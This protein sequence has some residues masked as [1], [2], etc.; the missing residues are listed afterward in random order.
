M[1]STG[2]R[3]L[4]P[5]PAEG[6]EAGLK[7]FCRQY[8]L[9]GEV[10][11]NSAQ[12]AGNICYTKYS[13]CQTTCNNGAYQIG[14]QYAAI[15]DELRSLGSECS[16]L[17]EYMVTLGEQG[18]DS[19][20]AAVYSA[21]CQQ[22]TQ[23]QAQSQSQS[24]GQGLGT[25]AAGGG[26][27]PY[28]DSTAATTNDPC[29]Q[30][31]NSAACVI[32]SNNPSH[33]AC[34]AL[35]TTE[36]KGQAGFKDTREEQEDKLADFNVGDPSEALNMDSMFA[37]NQLE[38][39]GMKYQTVAN[40]S[41][42]GIPGEGG[43]S[44]P[45][46]LGGGSRGSPGSPGYDT[47]VDEGFRSGGGGGGALAGAGTGAGM[48]G[49]LGSEGYF[50]GYGGS[51]EGDRSPSS[52][53]PGMDLSQYLPGGSRDPGQHLGGHRMRP[54]SAEIN[55]KFVDIWSRITVRMQEKCRLGEL[56]GCQ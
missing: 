14:G 34:V 28:S 23:A 55:G 9:T 38:P 27:E 37:N 25:G 7:E 11:R 42:G 49:D 29:A 2:K 13:S 19:G 18:L 24:P 44:S 47:D 26:L 56:L 46:Q 5:P 12:T 10:G 16:R 17:S 20:A 45:A 21:R 50:G 48:S 6:D 43:N 3:Y 8:Q 31:P 52:I 41:G 4:P 1:S 54:A 22:L 51:G 32:C 15:A 39:Q 53:R 40:N 33:P 36:S 30:D 35:A